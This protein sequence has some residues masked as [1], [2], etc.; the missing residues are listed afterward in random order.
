MVA[1]RRFYIA[2]T[3]RQLGVFCVGRYYL[4][5]QIKPF[6]EASEEPMRL[7]MAIVWTKFKTYIRVLGAAFSYLDRF[8]VELYGLMDLN[9]L[10]IL[11][12]RKVCALTIIQELCIYLVIHGIQG[13]VFKQY[14]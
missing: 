11:Q 7:R 5:Y 9:G 1:T 14:N 8:Y 6:L 4:T 13:Y 12:F 2:G 10:A 3:G